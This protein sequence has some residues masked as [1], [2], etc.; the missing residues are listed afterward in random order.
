MQDK[1]SIDVRLFDEVITGLTPHKIRVLETLYNFENRWAS[2][3]QIARALGKNRLTPHDIRAINILVGV[4]LVEAS[5]RPIASP[6]SDVINIYHVPDSV[7]ELMLEWIEWRK[8]NGHRPL[9][10]TRQ[11]ISLLEHIHEKV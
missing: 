11:P 2:R 3:L 8:R 5:T 10:R 7:A 6:L 9:M 1:M 4:G